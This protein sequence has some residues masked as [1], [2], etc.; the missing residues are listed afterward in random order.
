MASKLSASL[1]EVIS[2]G[3][4]AERDAVAYLSVEKR[5]NGEVL[6]KA[7]T[8]DTEIKANAPSMRSAMAVERMWCSGW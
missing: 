2:F 7:D 5:K 6:R 8:E 4:N 1:E 3:R